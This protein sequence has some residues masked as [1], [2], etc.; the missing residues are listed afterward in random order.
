[1]KAQ[2]T[3]VRTGLTRST[4]VAATALLSALPA[5][6]AGAVTIQMT[7]GSILMHRLTPAPFD[8]VFVTL[9]GE[10]FTL[11]NNFTH[12]SFRFTGTPHPAFQLLSPGTHVEFSGQ[13]SPLGLAGDALLV[14]NGVSY[15]ASGLINVVTPTVVVGADCPLDGFASQCESHVT[16]PF[17]LS[18]TIHGLALTGF[19]TVDIDISGSG[20]VTAGFLE[21]SEDLLG[22]EVIVYDIVPVP[23]PTSL[24]LLVSGLV[25]FGVRH[26]R[27]HSG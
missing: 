19:D 25:G 16:A 4:F 7:G 10:G 13:V 2:S 20:F 27:R 6:Q 15:S 17:I 3:G 18:G 5:T 26:R 9:M 21:V 11:T 22:L 8:D 1:M 14:L 12:D 24:T 23:E